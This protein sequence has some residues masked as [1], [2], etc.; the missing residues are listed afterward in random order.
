MLTSLVLVAL[1]AAQV[2]ADDLYEQLQKIDR[3]TPEVLVARAVTPAVVLIETK[4]VRLRRM[5]P[6]SSR[7]RQE[8]TH[9]S[10]SGVVVRPDGYIVTNYHV[11]KGA[12]EIHVSFQHDD[13]VY[14]AKRVS[15]HPDDDLALLLITRILPKARGALG[16]QI[17]PAEALIGIN[18]ETPG[19]FPVARMGTSADLMPGERVVAI[20]NPHGQSHTVSTGIIS[21]LGRSMSI[22]S[23]GLEF[24]GMIQTDA[25][26]NFGNSGGPL[27]NIRGEM[28]GIN[29]AVNSAAEN[30]GF[31]IPVDKIKDVLEQ[32]L[33]PKAA[34]SWLGME[35]VDDGAGLKVGYVWIDGPADEIGICAGDRIV[36]L[37]DTVVNDLPSYND[38]GLSLLPRERV[39][40]AYQRPGNSKTIRA[41]I[42]SWDK[43]DGYLYERL[44]MTVN[45]V[46]MDGKPYL[47][48][49]RLRA[50]GPA[51]DIGLQKGDWLPHMRHRRGSDR[52]RTSF[53]NRR[54]LKDAIDAYE[55]GTE[56]R[57]DVYRDDNED[58]EF[59][60][61]EHYEGVLTLR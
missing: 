47:M 39:Q 11:V 2:S 37:G 21:G 6:F 17:D 8:V 52:Y 41:V 61:N 19:P 56:M 49:D 25:S 53:G 34:V 32:Q 50:G 45:E 1:C 12:E 13:R 60:S 15:M 14:E 7:T 40:V 22:P 9:G 27:L 54:D 35:L 18:T 48:V 57:I 33:Y 24:R 38:A 31:A 58:F 10:G 42:A 55:A 43:M 51:S 28:I 23:Q 30:I 29:T 44:G 59:T 36:A 3:V 16:R 4:A 46:D 26:I 5:S 20:G